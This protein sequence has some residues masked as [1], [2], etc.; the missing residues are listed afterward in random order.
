MSPLEAKFSPK[1]PKI[2]PK[3]APKFLISR[4]NPE[5]NLSFL[6]LLVEYNILIIALWREEAGK[7]D[8]SLHMYWWEISDLYDP[9]IF[10]TAEASLIQCSVIFRNSTWI[11]VHI[12][13]PRVGPRSE[14]TAS[15]RSQRSPRRAERT[16]AGEAERWSELDPGA[17]QSW[18]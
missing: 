8:W 14:V 7:S 17:S 1:P 6:A 18:V 5:T 9:T 2:S 4:R 11:Y 16:E 12:V 3:K 13:K 10:Y 15:L